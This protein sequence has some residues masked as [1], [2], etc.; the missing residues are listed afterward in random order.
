MLQAMYAEGK[1]A[2]IP[3]VKFAIILLALVIL[4]FLLFLISKFRLNKLISWSFVILYV[5]FIAYALVQQ[6]VCDKYLC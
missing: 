6:L 3:H 5:I 1:F 4:I 2:I